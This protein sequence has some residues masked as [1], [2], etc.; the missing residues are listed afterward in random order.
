M[1][2]RS[3]FSGLQGKLLIY[4]LL[5]A[6][7]PLIV[8]TAISYKKSQT[9]LVAMSQNMLGGMADG[10][11]GKLDAII[12]ARYDDIK[13]WADNDAIREGFKTK[14]F[15][16]AHNL[17]ASIELS[18]D[19]YKE[20]LLFDTTGNCVAASDT[21]IFSVEGFQRNQAE[22]E[23]FK[24]AMAGQINFIDVHFSPSIKE[25]VIGF[26]APVIDHSG[27]IIGVLTTRM[28]WSYFEK[29]VIEEGKDGKTG[30]AYLINKEGVVIAHPKKENVLKTNYLKDAGKSMAEVAG[31]MVKG[32]KGIGHYTIGGVDKL[33][34]F[35]PSKGDGHFKGMGWSCAM[36]INDSEINAPIYN[37]RNTILLIISISIFIISVLA[38][39]IARSISVP[40]LRGVAFAQAIASGDMTG[41]LDVKSKD[42]VG[43]LADALNTM[44]ENLS[45]MIGKIRG[46]SG[47]LAAA[48]VEISTNSDQLT[49]AAHSQ[50]SAAEETSATMVQMAASIQTV[51]NN[52]DSLASN[53]DEVASSVQELGA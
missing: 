14:D 39:L 9:A 45:N 35:T 6:L 47:Q 29:T 1:K 22:K 12:S 51:A 15:K 10:L 2:K 8:V 41:Q 5:M 53:T 20:V 21:N 44:V 38:V 18:Y 16:A 4:F 46:S 52:T 32:E 49:R 37:L 11:M 30:Y 19:L 3:F 31:K 33:A 24:R 23:W 26:S 13:A 17:M 28:P 7:V 25:N 50:A 42:E 27:K 43:D 34:G 48:A 40:M 36:V